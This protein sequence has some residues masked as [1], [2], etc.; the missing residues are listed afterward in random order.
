L[1]LEG[2]VWSKALI[3]ACAAS[4]TGLKQYDRLDLFA[5]PANNVT[6]V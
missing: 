2:I 4:T 3:P 6:H 5:T 1:G